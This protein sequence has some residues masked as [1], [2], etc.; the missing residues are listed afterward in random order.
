MSADLWE[1]QAGEGVKPYEAFCLYRDMGPSRSTTKVAEKLSKSEQLIRRWSAAYDWV[2]RA[3]SW[4]DEQDR[5]ARQ[6]QLDEIVKMR[7]RHAKLAEDML[8]KAAAALNHIPED[9]IKAGDVSR[10]V[11]IASK[12][13][14]ISRG[15]VGDVVEERDGGKAVDPVQIYIPSNGRNRGEESFDDLE[16]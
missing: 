12:L 4:D 16:V 9:E 5:K 3:G 15:D 11:D 2:K 13:E 14:R 8:F 1:R 7:K 6:A 10:M